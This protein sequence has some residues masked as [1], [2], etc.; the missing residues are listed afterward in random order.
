MEN[1]QE[2]FK[3]LR[4]PCVELSSVGL[5]FRGQ[6]ATANDVYR[7][8][9][10]VYN[11]LNDLANKNALDAKLAE[12]AFFPLSHIF[13][14]TKRA[15]ANLLE[16]AVNCLKI[17][18]TKGWRRNLSPALGKQLIILLTLIVGGIPSNISGESPK[19]QPVELSIAGF[20]CLETIF[21]VLDGPVARQTVYHEI[22]TSTVVDQT[23]YLLLEGITDNRSDELCIAAA[24]ALEILT[25]RITDRVVL[26]SIMPRTVSALTKVIKPTTQTRRSYRMICVC[27]RT[28]DHVLK[29]VL[30]DQAAM[31]LE[32]TA[33]RSQSAGDQLV[34]DKSWL[35]ATATQIKLALTSIVQ[36]RRHER[37]EVREALLE[38]CIMVVEYCRNTLHE[39]IPT[40]IETIVVL[41]DA[42]A[43]VPDKPYS[44]LKHMATTYPIVVDSLRDS[45]HT[46]IT[47]FPRTMQGN[48]ETAKQWAFKQI[49]TAFQILSE[50]Q[51]S[52]DILTT[53][54]ASGLCDSVAAS[55]IHANKSLGMLSPT[56][57][58]QSMDIIHQGSHSLS[59]APVL[60]E[61]RSQQHTL[62]D[63]QAMVSRLSGFDSGDEITRFI[64]NRVHNEPGDSKIAPFWLALTFLRADAHGSA[65]FDELISSD[66]LESSTN[67]T[68]TSMI[69]ELYYASL[70]I[71]NEQLSDDPRDWRISALALEAVA[72]QAQQLGEAFRPEL[73]D[74]LYPVLQLLS[75]GNPYL[76]QHAMTCLN[77][78][79]TSCKYDSTSSMI[80]ENVDYL[81]NAV[82]LKLN[83]FDVSP[84]PPQV[85]FMMVKLCGA[86][87]IPYLDDLVDSIF[88][89]LDMYHG[90]PKL[91]ETMFKTLA[92]I[93]EEGTKQPS[94]LAIENGREGPINHR[95]RQ[96][97]GF[98]VSTLAEDL[99]KQRMKRTKH[100]Q[101]ALEQDEK[102]SH[103]KRPWTAEPKE[104]KKSNFD[105]VFQETQAA[106]ETGES[107][108]QLPPPREPDDSEKPL[109]KS[110]SLLLHI[111]K[112]IPVHLSSPSPYLRRS[113]LSILIQAIPVLAQHE[114]SLLPL[115]N[116]LWPPVAARITFPASLNTTP[117]S[118]SSS[119]ALLTSDTSN[120]PND[121][122]ASPEPD[123]QE[124]TFVTTAACTAIQS[125][126]QNAGDFM[127]TRVE[128][129][130]P[131]WARL[132]RRA[133]DR[134]RSDA[135][136]AIE[137]RA[138]QSS[139]S[140]F[141][142]SSQSPITPLDTNDSSTSQSLIPSLSL[143]TAGTRS[144]T[145]HHTLWR[146]LITLFTTLL[147]HVRLP[148]AI[149]DEICEFI[150]AW[151]VRFAGPDAPLQ[152]SAHP[153]ESKDRA[154]LDTIRDAIV[155]METWN[156]DLA[157]FVLER[158]RGEV[159]RLMAGKNSNINAKTAMSGAGGGIARSGV[160]KIR[161]I[162]EE[163]QRE[164][165]FSKGVM[166]FA[167]PVF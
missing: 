132:Y 63:L 134:V 38:L 145:P 56:R 78:L 57:D 148:L 114:N 96:Y 29:S 167:R 153:Q 106:P 5:K 88:G 147:T 156:A 110:H 15:P 50:I 152:T 151:V 40:V 144:F 41:S 72:L 108:E 43:T 89:V 33:T 159:R 64:I 62:K 22:G 92:A 65:F 54:L 150:G 35:T 77:L 48:D 120:N 58:I 13:N 115:I 113:L 136:K 131:R 99:T 53:N 125:M 80:I 112:S 149:G 128:A 104:D 154:E 21:D 82:G 100:A 51:S 162:E 102:L 6:Q 70:P 17:L 123:L 93:V 164:W 126:C 3:K 75:S 122:K 39:S 67:S 118:S 101:E 18:V 160:P 121:T 69:E 60:F 27:L 95:K 34:L 7:V 16:L 85:L 81:I 98:Q 36:V 52:S 116:D 107:N 146:A 2:S 25:Q 24:K 8:L 23:V 49:S 109:S 137:R 47:A 130:F 117:S 19:A 59:F 124:E 105:T 143:T 61:H 90:Y 37:L 158:Q 45:L 119:T 111:V 71:L 129:E 26:A 86:R 155:A 44:S 66:L 79:T 1:S 30:N 10:P 157:W 74:A 165:V 42:E 55:I 28:L 103:P 20:E 11:V 135:D 139:S 76:Q 87:L 84:F 91:V 138:R 163:P 73:M 4:G 46:W 32:E 14:E 68:R 94:L 142:P 97:Q 140:P 166:R 133:W 12:Y 31:I 9:N 83:M 161:E 141:S 127:A